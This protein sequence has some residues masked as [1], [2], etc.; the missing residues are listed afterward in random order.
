[1]RAYFRIDSF[2]GSLASRS[3]VMVAF[4]PIVPNQS[5]GLRQSFEVTNR[6]EFQTSL[7]CLNPRSEFRQREIWRGWPGNR[8]TTRYGPRYSAPNRMLFSSWGTD[9][10]VG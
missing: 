8:K 5:R 4:R 10:N 9:L 3:R 2:D 7:G 1:M 6:I